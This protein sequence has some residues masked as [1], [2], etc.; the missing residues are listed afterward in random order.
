MSTV[1]DPLLRLLQRHYGDRWAIRRTSHLWIA[2]VRDRDV[3][4]APTLVE[5]DI[6]DFVR[7]LEHPPPGSGRSLLSSGWLHSRL[8]P[9]DTDDDAYYQDDR[10]KS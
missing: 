9:L 6:E 8:D 2:T 7:E 10:S 3:D 5:H 1:E 4:H